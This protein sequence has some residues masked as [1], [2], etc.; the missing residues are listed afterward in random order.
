[1]GVV[2]LP[3]SLTAKTEAK[4]AD[5]MA[6]LNAILTQ[7]NG[8]L[9]LE[10]LAESLK[11]A[12]IPTASVIGTARSSAPTGFLLCQGQEVSRTTFSVLFAAIGTTYG[13]GNGTTTFNVPDF[14][15]RVPVGPDAGA[16]RVE[17]K[18]GTP[19]LL[20]QAGGHQML[21]AHFHQPG[22]MATSIESVTHT[23]FLGWQ[24]F[25]PRHEGGGFAYNDVEPFG[26]TNT[27]TENAFHTHTVVGNTASEGLG[28]QQN[29]SPY[30]VL[31]WIIKT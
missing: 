10:N 28:N 1:M 7:V 25:G 4:A 19:N 8:K 20:G 31:N 23:H 9:D 18:W 22:S 3:K 2:V 17:S 13:A 27:T 29:M 11:N 26:G 21:Q 16:N 12:L 24:A 15:G 30:Q 6:D 14:R 5:V